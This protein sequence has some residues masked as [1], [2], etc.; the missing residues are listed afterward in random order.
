VPVAVTGGVTDRRCAT[1]SRIAS[2]RQIGQPGRV[3]SSPFDAL[4]GGEL[5]AVSFVRDYVELRIDSAIVRLLTRPSGRIAGVAWQLTD[6]SGADALRRLIGRTV[7]SVDFDEDDHLR[8]SFDEGTY[9]DASLRDEDRSGPE[10]LH[11][12]PADANGHVHAASMS[13]W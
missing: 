2:A 9:I 1:P 7:V 11:L 5:D 4:V 3:T 8:L 13:V 12:M 6:A 10:A